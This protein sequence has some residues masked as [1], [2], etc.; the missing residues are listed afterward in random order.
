MLI[1]QRYTNN[2]NIYDYVSKAYLMVV[3]SR[4]HRN[5]GHLLRWLGF[6]HGQFQQG[7]EFNTLLVSLQRRLLLI[8]LQPK[9]V[10]R[11]PVCLFVLCLSVAVLLLIKEDITTREN[12]S[13]PCAYST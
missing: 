1:E 8:W 3:I 11:R 7:S 12:S 5:S 13:L 4:T 10:N 6:F 2:L 9:Y